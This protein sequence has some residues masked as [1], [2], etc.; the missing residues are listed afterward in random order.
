MKG[1]IIKGIGGFY[2]IKTENG[3]FECKARGKFRN[4]G[5]TPVVGDSVTITLKD[6]KGAIE[7]IDERK[8]E[9]IRPSVSN[10]S[11]ALIVFALKNPNINLELLNKFILQ[12]ELKNI[13]SVICFN[14]VDL[15]E[16][17][18]EHEAI[19]MIKSAEYE[20]IFLSAKAGKGLDIIKDKLKDNVTVFCGPSG[21]GKSTIL[22]GIVGREVME[23]G[24]ISDKL[25]RGKHT[26]RH[27][28]LVEVNE[29]L[30]VDT[31]GFSTLE[32]IFE[33]KEE[34][35]DYFPDFSDYRQNCK[36]NGCLHYKEPGCQVKSAVEENKI[37]NNRYQFYVK[38]LEE[39]IKGGKNKW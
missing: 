37:D 29:G 27:S 22:N 9:L 24:S 23:T 39:A 38:T 7:D 25:K 32:L 31:P 19:K 33:N 16:N 10:I 35:Q 36:F 1:I 28:E 17:Y 8:N 6:N 3:V 5:L 21:V 12:C 18:E 11:Q 20:C 2:Y 34:V 26:T 13:K 4:K 14:K 30:V 15:V